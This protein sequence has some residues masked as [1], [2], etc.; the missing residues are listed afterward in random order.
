MPTRMAAIQKSEIGFIK[1]PSLIIHRHTPQ[2]CSSASGKN[3]AQTGSSQGK[4]IYRLSKL[5]HFGAH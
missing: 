1:D 5:G 4:K 3:L 2:F